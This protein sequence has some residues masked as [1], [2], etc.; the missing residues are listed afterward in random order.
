MGSYKLTGE[1]VFEGQV[2]EL[3]FSVYQSNLAMG[4]AAAQEAATLLI[5]VLQQQDTANIIL[6]SANSQL[7]FLDALRKVNRVNWSRV[8][9]FHMDEYLDLEAGHPASFAHF[10]Q[11]HFVES[12]HPAAF[13]PVPAWEKDA[14][15]ACMQ[16]QALLHQYPADLCVL[17]FGENG[18]LAFNDPPFADFNDPAWVKIVQLDERSRQQQVGEGHFANLDNVPTH[19]IT[20]TIPALL[21]AKSILALVPESRKAQAVTR[22]LLGPVQEDCPASVLRRAP[23][24]HLY[25]DLDSAAGMLSYKW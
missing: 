14:E 2:D 10:L 22:A 21:S 1:L 12:I 8:N 17:G 13:F 24:A 3:V 5:Q 16:Y 25:L 6:A 4:A 7:S 19:A 23:H 20:L 11:R 18:H 9:V 15:R